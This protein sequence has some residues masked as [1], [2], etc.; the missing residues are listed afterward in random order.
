MIALPR[1][2]AE[3]VRETWPTALGLAA[4]FALLLLIGLFT[5]L[6]GSGAWMLLLVPSL[7]FVAAMAAAMLRLSYLKMG[8]AA[9]LLLHLLLPLLLKTKGIN[10]VNNWQ[11]LA[12]GLGLTG[13][14]AL[15][16]E[17]GRDG[18][19]R[20]SLICYCLFLALM[21]LSAAVAGQSRG[22]AAAY[23]LFSLLKPLL[24]LGA[25]F[26]LLRLAA[27]GRPLWWI[28]DWSW[29]PLL[30]L[31]AWQWGAPGSYTQ[32]FPY[33]HGP[34][35]DVGGLLPS[36]AFGVYEHPGVLASFTAA[37][38]LMA[39]L[40]GLN[41]PQQRRRG[42]LLALIYFALLLASGE[43][44][45]LAAMLVSLAALYLW[46]RRGQLA[47]R[48]VLVLPMVA[49]LAV[50]YWM[51]YGDT[52]VQ[53][54]AQWGGA[55][56]SAIEHPRAQLYEG[57]AYLANKH[58]PLGSGLGTYGGAGAAKFD[59]SIYLSLGF[60]RHWWFG[61]D[62]YLLDIFWHNALGEGGWFALV[63]QVL[64]YLLL[65]A[66]ALRHYLGSQGLQRVYWGGAG[67]GMIY[68]LGNSLASPSFQDPRLF[69]W[70]ALCF[71]L[72]V[73]QRQADE[74]RAQ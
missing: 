19:L 12:M 43:R 63:A 17:A 26:A 16:R 71:G 64:Q 4:L 11:F 6:A 23:Q 70:T 49:L 54:A 73:Q 36:R 67:F 7:A 39:L 58:F 10:W 65:S 62:N 52:L 30:A 18:L 42:L 40:R 14:L 61:E 45:E 47:S 72:A 31:V 25:G 60:G 69:V 50:G 55:R 35:S 20:A 53:E 33:P 38:T 9:L 2:T 46:N 13:L 3:R 15:A 44:G 27:P 66:Y 22:L 8:I 56:H 68:I 51:L 48:L 74:A 41:L 29:L 28:N 24:M 32:V 57:A 37:M 5:G 21:L 59:L 34:A 1:L